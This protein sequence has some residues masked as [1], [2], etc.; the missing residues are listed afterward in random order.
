MKSIGGSTLCS[1]LATGSSNAS[2]VH[3]STSTQTT[4]Y[5]DTG[6]AGGTDLFNDGH[7]IN[8]HFMEAVP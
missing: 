4:T 5:N 3:T 6:A 1:S 2:C 8:A 7:G